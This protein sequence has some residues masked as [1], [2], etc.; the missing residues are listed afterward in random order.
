MAL[1]IVI[2][3]RTSVGETELDLEKLVSK[4]RTGLPF[5]I[6]SGKIVSSGLLE[7]LRTLTVASSLLTVQD[8]W[9]KRLDVM[10][11]GCVSG[12]THNSPTVKL[13]AEHWL[14][15]HFL[16]N[17][18][19]VGYLKC[20]LSL[21]FLP[22]YLSLSLLLAVGFFPSVSLPQQHRLN[23]Q[24]MQHKTKMTPGSPVSWLTVLI[25]LNCHR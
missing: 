25:C 4:Q 16:I 23:M 1:A 14:M 6:S 7:F 22:S 2:K 20:V 15:T 21:H 12:G 24:S 5:K 8:A 10:N 11:T 18:K 9:A 13:P 19:N 17:S 3:F